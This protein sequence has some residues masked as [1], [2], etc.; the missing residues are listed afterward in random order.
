MENV[1]AMQDLQVMIALKSFVST[2][3]MIME[4]AILPKVLAIAC[5]IFMEMIVGIRNALKTVEI[6]VNVLVMESVY[7]K[8][9]M[10]VNTA[11]TRHAKKIATKT[12]SATMDNAFV[13]KDLEELIVRMSITH[14]TINLK[15]VLKIV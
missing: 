4:S 9:A 5:L 13:M 3:V 14:I 15:F 12:D 6:E 10:K 7:V 2:V 1:N 11:N 8:K